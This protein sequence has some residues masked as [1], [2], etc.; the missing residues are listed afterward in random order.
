MFDWL[1]VLLSPVVPYAETVPQKDYIGLV[2]AEAAYSALLPESAP[3]KPKVPTKDC[4]TCNGTGR[5]RSGDNIS[6]TKCPDCEGLPPGQ[7]TSR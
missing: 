4:K 1:F 2:A 3:V 6:W 5:V 7:P